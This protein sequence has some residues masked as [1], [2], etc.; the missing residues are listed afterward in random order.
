MKRKKIKIAILD[1]MILDERRS[2]E[3][4]KFSVDE[5]GWV[6]SPLPET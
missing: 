3:L 5:N 1:D 6:Q 4:K 2:I